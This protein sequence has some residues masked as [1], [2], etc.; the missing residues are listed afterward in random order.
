V[1]GT[2]YEEAHTKL[3]APADFDGPIS[4]RHCTDSVCLLFLLVGWMAM[5]VIGGY[6]VWNGDYR[7]VIYPMDYDGNVCGVELKGGGVDMTDYPYLYYVNYYT[8]GVCVKSCPSLQLDTTDSSNTTAT[9]T[10]HNDTNTYRWITEDGLTDMRTLITYSGVWQTQDGSAE[11][12]NATTSTTDAEQLNAVRTLVSPYYYSHR[13]TADT[14]ANTGN[15]T[16]TTT[17][18]QIVDDDDEESSAPS[19]VCTTDT[20]F[21]NN[22]IANSWT[23]IGINEGYGYAYYLADSYEW[24]GRCY[25][26]S[27]AER[28]IAE[29]VMAEK[30]DEKEEQVIGSTTTNNHSSSSSSSRTFP[31]FGSASNSVITSSTT[32]FFTNLYSDLW[33]SRVYIVGFGFGMSLLV[34]IVYMGLLRTPCLLTGLV[35]CSIIGVIGIF[36][37]GGYFAYQTA[38]DWKTMDPLPVR[39]EQIDYTEYASYV[40]FGIAGILLISGLCFRSE[41]QLATT[42]IQHASAAL[43]SMVLVLFIPILQFG[44]LLLFWCVWAVYSIHLASMGTIGTQTYDIPGSDSDIQLT[45]RVYEYNDVTKYCGWFLLFIFWWTASFIVAMGDMMVAMAISK[46]YFTV[47]RRTINSCTV[48]ASIGTVCRYHMG[49][50][51]Y[52]S[53][54]IAI[55]KLIRYIITKF[56]TKVKQYLSPTLAACMFCCCQCC[57]CCV[58]QFLQFINKNAYIQCAISGT[59]FGESGRKAFFLIVRNAGRIGTV[60]YVSG[61]VLV[62]G[63]VFISILTTTMGYYYLVEYV[64]IDLHSYGGPVLTIFILSYFVADMFMDVFDISILTILHCFVADE[65]MFDGRARYADGSL[66]DWINKHANDN[67]VDAIVP[68]NNA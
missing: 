12:A 64:D 67:K 21:P 50:C 25:I 57:L 13:S 54:I 29:L 2:H 55:V 26:T 17:T 48:L 23:S 41:I 8:G 22:T 52:G 1:N 31:S 66:K 30:G 15:G 32:T 28:R 7:W 60:S 3:Y 62:I 18:D 58:E 43:N 39:P 65:E 40:L 38:Q 61:M 10:T 5:S 14:N 46:W 33:E 51:A 45:I 36:I 34:S 35:W 24:F 11:L 42:C 49:T 53:L 19:P 16:I 68:Y 27:D 63:K 9:A 37:F 44:G 6:V 4:E 47:D 59:P 56:Q 20:C